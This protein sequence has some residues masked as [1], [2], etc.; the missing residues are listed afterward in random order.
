MSVVCVSNPDELTAILQHF[1]KRTT[2]AEKE[3]QKKLA[4]QWTT[5]VQTGVDLTDE[6]INTITVRV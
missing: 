4:N 2:K 5:S 6:L 3:E 1:N